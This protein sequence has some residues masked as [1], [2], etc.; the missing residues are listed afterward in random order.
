MK[1]SLVGG[2]IGA[3]VL[4]NA[5]AFVAVDQ[6]FQVTAD[7]SPMASSSEVSAPPS[8]ASS[9]VTSAATATTATATAASGPVR[10]PG[11]FVTAVTAD[12]GWRAFNSGGCNGSVQV[13]ATQDGGRTWSTVAKPP[14]GAADAIGIDG[15][16]H[17]QLSGQ[18]SQGCAQQS[19][20]LGTA[21]S[22]YTS[23]AASWAPKDAQSS[24]VIHGGKQQKACASGSVIDIAT[25]GNAADVLCSDGTVRSVSADGKAQTVYQGSGLIS[26]GTTS[27]NTLVVARSA[28][29]CDGVQLDKV[30]KGGSAQQVTCVKGA[31]KAVDLTFAGDNGWLVAAHNTW[32][33]TATGAW[34][35]S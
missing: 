23:T 29:G 3:L 35:K 5:A 6:H 25:A 2:A 17:L 19:W 21:G 31:S 18:A 10:S 13:Q 11:V 28:S 30:V 34:S 22:W 24:A 4:V 1:V 32:T 15:S 7:A 16:G 26:I 9:A 20:S 12:R 8:T 14:A 33:G 27:D